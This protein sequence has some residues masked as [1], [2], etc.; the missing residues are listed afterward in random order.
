ME[1]DNRI[2]AKKWF[3]VWFVGLVGQLLWNV[4]NAIFNTFAYQVA[5][6]DAPRVI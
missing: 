4:E 6:H 3:V 1:S 2:G 5:S